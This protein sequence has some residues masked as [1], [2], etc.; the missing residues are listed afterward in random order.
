MKRTVSDLSDALVQLGFN[1]DHARKLAE[2]QLRSDIPHVENA[3]FIAIVKSFMTSHDDTDKI[4]TASEPTPAMLKH[5]I[6]IRSRAELLGLGVSG[7]ALLRFERVV[8]TELL[9]DLFCFL[10]GHYSNSSIPVDTF[11]ICSVDEMTEE[12]TAH[13]TSLNEF[14]PQLD[15]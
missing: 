5:N 14:I 11:H 1:T 4:E 2:E 8:Q 3:S 15:A 9:N 13:L 12:V 6:M 7:D 10:S